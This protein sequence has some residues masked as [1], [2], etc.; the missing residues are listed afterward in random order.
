M[1]VRRLNPGERTAARVK[2]AEVCLQVGDAHRRVR[3]SVREKVAQ[4]WLSGPCLRQLARRAPRLL[5]GGFNGDVLI[6]EC[7]Q[8]DVDMLEESLPTRGMSVHAYWLAR[9]AAG[10]A[11]YLIAFIDARPVGSCV[12]RWAGDR[13][14]QISG[15]LPDCPA[16]M[17]LHVGP[18]HRGRGVGTALIRFAEATVQGRGYR[19]VTMGVGQ[20]N[21]RALALYTRLG[22]R[23]SVLRCVSRYDYPDDDG[24]LREVVEHNTALV[25][26]LHP[27]DARP[28]TTPI[29]RNRGDRQPSNA[30][31]RTPTR[32]ACQS[33]RS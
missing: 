10:E 25:R 24:V 23:D 32:N 33:E 11:T 22:Y 28:A 15:A 9:Q 5:G 31:P 7:L 13:D 14:P 3:R 16:I 19:R 4:S 2:I 6:R 26:D 17:N 21:P 30:P 20:D 29:E 1:A 27:T 18:V 8:A 12:I